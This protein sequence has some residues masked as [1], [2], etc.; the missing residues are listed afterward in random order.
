MLPSNSLSLEPDAK[1]DPAKP[2]FASDLPPFR[3]L[4]VFDIKQVAEP[5]LVYFFKSYIHFVRRK[6]N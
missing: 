2:S 1:V 6:K 4:A 3:K 5:V